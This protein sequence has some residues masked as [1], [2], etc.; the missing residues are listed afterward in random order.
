MPFRLTTKSTTLNDFEQLLH[1][2]LLKNASFRAHHEHLNEDRPTLSA[3]KM[4]PNDSSF[5]Q[6]NFYSRGFSG[7]GASDFQFLVIL[8]AMSFETLETR[9][10]LLYSD[11]ES[12]IGFTTDPKSRD[13]E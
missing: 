10:A 12:L 6:Y 3:A 7:K 1:A 9:L 11:V 4:L 2:L 8:L 5:W 13:L